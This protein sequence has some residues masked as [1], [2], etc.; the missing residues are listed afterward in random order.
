MRASTFNFFRTFSRQLK[1]NTL[2]GIYAHEFLR[3]SSNCELAI[4]KKGD[5]L[6]DC[7]SM[8]VE[9]IFKEAKQSTNGQR[10]VGRKIEDWEKVLRADESKLRGGRS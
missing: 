2:E 10:N 7:P 6:R 8:T 4:F 5:G 9:E 3:V 1:V